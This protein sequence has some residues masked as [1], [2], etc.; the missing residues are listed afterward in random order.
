MK[1]QSR[2]TFCQL[3]CM[4]KLYKVNICVCRFFGIFIMYDNSVQLSIHLV[5]FLVKYDIQCTCS[6]VYMGMLIIML[7][8]IIYF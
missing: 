5:K 1:Q 2:K 3:K 6:M 4:Y 7:G 8:L